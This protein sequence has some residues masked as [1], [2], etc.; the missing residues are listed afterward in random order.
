M[1]ELVKLA[2]PKFNENN[3]NT[4]TK[5]YFV[6]GLHPDMQTALKTSD[7]FESSDAKSLA[8]EV[9]RLQLAGIKSNASITQ[10]SAVN[11]V[12]LPQADVIDQITKGRDKRWST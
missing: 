12:D 1:A 11:N 6:R 10:T 3:R 7:K 2:Y 8:N 4:I 5:D 9:T